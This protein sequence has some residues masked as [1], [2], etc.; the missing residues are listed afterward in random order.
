VFVDGRARPGPPANVPLRR[1]TE[2]VLEA[3]P[4]VPPHPAYT[5]PPG[6]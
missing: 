5:F 2:I 1:H 3:G 6:T 4:Y